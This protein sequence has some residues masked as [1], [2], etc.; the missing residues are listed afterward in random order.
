MSQAD[1]NPGGVA[2]W[3]GTLTGLL[4]TLGSSYVAL[5]LGILQ[6]V[7][8]MRAIG[9]T[10]QGLRRLVDLFNKWLSNTH[11]G[12]LHGLS[13]QLPMALGRG[14]E[15][16]A[17]ELEDVGAWTVLALG[18]AGSLAM[19]A[20]AL[21][22]P[23]YQLL[24]REILAVGAAIIWTGQAYSVYSVVLRAWGRLP[25]SPASP[26]SRS[27]W[28]APTSSES[29]ALRWAGWS[30]TSSNSS[31]WPGRPASRCGCAGTGAWPGG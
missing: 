17:Q 29:G 11:L 28:A 6:G 23:G 16:R 25:W 30:A 12:A 19:L 7:L 1:A 5:L 22:W 8:V 18:L 4:M 14:Q 24:T 10:G 13:K 27:S 21:F 15:E 20:Y 26:V 9:P 3:Q 2:S 31:I